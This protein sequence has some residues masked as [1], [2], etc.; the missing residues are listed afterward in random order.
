MKNITII[1]PL[2]KGKKYL[3][4]LRDMIELNAKNAKYI[5]NIEWIVVNDYPEEFIGEINTTDLVKTTVINN[6]VN[7][8]IQGSRVTGLKASKGEYILFLDQD[9]EIAPE[10][11]VSQSEKIKDADAVVCDCIF[12]GKP[13][14]NFGNV[15]SLEECIKK[16]YNISE[17]CGFVPGQVLLRKEAIAEVWKT[18]ILSWSCCDDRYLWL[19]M[20]ANNKKFKTNNE[21][22]YIHNVSGNNQSWVTPVRH[23]SHLE[24]L[25]IVK[26][27][28][29]FSPD[30][31]GKLSDSIERET[32][33][34]LEDRDF[35][36]R[37]MNIY[38]NILLFK[39]YEYYL[40]KKINGIKN[41]RI[42]IYGME[43]G[44]HIYLK[45]KDEGIIPVCIIDRNAKKNVEEIPIFLP[46][47][48]PNDVS[49]VINTIIRDEKKVSDFIKKKYPEIK[50]LKIEDLLED[51]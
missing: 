10:W 45:L 18:R 5:C 44:K 30:E 6:K 14:Y 2:Y 41:E 1:T 46:D 38:K 25:N 7:K 40:S 37:K 39:E 28:R 24:M 47:E 22:F 42:A 23:R 8:G 31:E 43:I 12:D 21:T 15:P 50:I 11:V 36:R 29:L 49:L 4:N 48:I 32:L 3:D 16:D 26:E 27:E 51:Y 33:F 9:D 35:L 34:F 19:C 20:F 13:Y 17:K